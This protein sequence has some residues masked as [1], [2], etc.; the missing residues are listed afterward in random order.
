MRSNTASDVPKRR[1]RSLIAS[2]GVGL[3]SLALVGVLFVSRPIENLA[4]TTP[5]LG[6]IAPS[7]DTNTITGK[8]FLLTRL[9]G[10]FVVVDFFASWCVPCIKEQPEL[11]TFVMEN[12]NASGA[13]LVAVIFNDSVTNIRRLLGPAVSLFPVVPD[14]SGIIG[15]NYG[16][17][18][19]PEKFLVDPSGRIVAK[20]VGGVT[21]NG[22]ETLIA[23][24]RISGAEIVAR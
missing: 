23:S 11:E 6:K 19:P 12:R 13:R 1:H 16:V 22:L 9:R 5:L 8:R 17:A 2:L 15:M 21:A 20:I 18:N 7:I 24:A 10:H 3:F 14:P 4:A